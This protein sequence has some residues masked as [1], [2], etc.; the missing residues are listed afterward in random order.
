MIGELERKMRLHESKP[1]VVLQI[2]EWTTRQAEANR[3]R[4]P[5]SPWNEV[6]GAF[7]E[8]SDGPTRFG[9]DGEGAQ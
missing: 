3:A 2:L 7:R 5:Y 1:M 4:K 9:D 8:L 6:T